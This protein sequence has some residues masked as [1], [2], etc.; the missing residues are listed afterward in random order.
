MTMS[1]VICR[2][3]GHRQAV[4]GGYEERWYG[5][6]WIPE[7]CCA[8]CGLPLGPRPFLTR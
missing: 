2:V 5:P 7:P 4:R 8:R 1:R 6:G 3:L